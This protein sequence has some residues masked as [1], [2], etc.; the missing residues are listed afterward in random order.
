MFGEQ[1]P[2]RHLHPYL[3]QLC[4]SVPNDKV[5]EKCIMISGEGESY[6]LPSERGGVASAGTSAFGADAMVGVLLEE[7]EVFW[8]VFLV[9]V[10]LR[11]LPTATSA[12]VSA[13]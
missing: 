7:P 6:S 3:R 8:I 12:R 9:L 4:L 2:G 10:I 13:L 11:F 5:C 1:S